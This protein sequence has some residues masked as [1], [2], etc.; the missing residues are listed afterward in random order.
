MLFENDMLN[1]CGHENHL[2]EICAPDALRQLSA[3]RCYVADAMTNGRV[4]RGPINAENLLNGSVLFSE[5]DLWG[6][7]WPDRG[8]TGDLFIDAGR[9]GDK[10]FDLS[11]WKLLCVL[12][13]AGENGKVEY[14]CDLEL[15]DGSDTYVV[16]P[17][18]V[19]GVM[20]APSWWDEI[21]D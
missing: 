18:F 11:R 10:S 14:Y 9:L 20:D 16:Q 3:L 6:W 5:Y 13:D 15:C 21:F 2:V 8:A 12:S 7:V 17:S 1:T 4:T 19:R